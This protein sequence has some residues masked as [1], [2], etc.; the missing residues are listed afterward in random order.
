MTKK[1]FASFVATG[2]LA[3]L[4]S[5]TAF[6]QSLESFIDTAEST[7]G[8]EAFIAEKFGRFA[9]I[10]LVSGN[11]LVEA[12]YDTNTGQLIESDIIPSSRLVQRFANALDIAVI[13]LSDA[14]D[15]AEAAVGGGDVLEAALLVGRRNSGRRFLVDIRTDSGVFDVLVDSANGNIIRVIRD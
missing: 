13:T 11:Q 12:L 9:E 2:L 14:I 15:A 1:V 8:G 10:Q 4:S 6:A 5:G 7:F 3:V